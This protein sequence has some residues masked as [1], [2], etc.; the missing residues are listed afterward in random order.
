MKQEVPEKLFLN[1]LAF[2]FQE[3][4]TFLFFIGRQS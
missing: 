2:D 3:H 4:V 1:T